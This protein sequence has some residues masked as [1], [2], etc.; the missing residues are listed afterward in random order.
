MARSG[1]W[2][3][4][5]VAV[6]AKPTNHTHFHANNAADL[7]SH[8]LRHTYAAHTY[9]SSTVPSLGT[10]LLWLLQCVQQGEVTA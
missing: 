4:G 6:G 2:G 8:T 9:T 1:G 5:G 10:A 7:H 3:Y